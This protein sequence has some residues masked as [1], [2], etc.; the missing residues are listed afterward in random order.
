M[1]LNQIE[2]K[3]MIQVFESSNYQKS[4]ESVVSH[5][6]DTAVA[7]AQVGI[8]SITLKMTHVDWPVFQKG[9]D[10]SIDKTRLFD[11]GN[12]DARKEFLKDVV[13]KLRQLL[14]GSSVEFFSERGCY[15]I[16]V[17]A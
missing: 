17:I 14:I 4:L 13:L 9:Q 2:L 16:K 6:Y 11:G 10:L 8:G 7:N 5:V 15:F 12:D 1:N 3:R